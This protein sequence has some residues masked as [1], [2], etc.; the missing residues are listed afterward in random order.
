M[1]TATGLFKVNG[2]IVCVQGDMHRC[3]IKDHNTTAVNSGNS[4]TSNGKPVIRVGDSA[5]CGAVINSGSPD[6]TTN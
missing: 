2:K 5:E 4:L 1:V 3:P 6:T